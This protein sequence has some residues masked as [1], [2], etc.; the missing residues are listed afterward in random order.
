MVAFEIYI[1]VL[2]L[3]VYVMLTAVFFLFLTCVAKQAIRLIKGG[4][5]DE[6]IYAEYV[7][8]EKKKKK[9][10]GGAE[11]LLSAVFCCL[12]ILVFAFATFINIT[13]TQKNLDFPTFRVVQSGSMSKK[14]EK[15][16]YLFDN[17]L[18]DQIQ[19]FDLI[20]TEKLPDEFDLK[21]YD[22]VVY[23]ADGTLVVHR[24]VQI[25]EP[26]E[27]HPNERYFRFQGDNVHVAD[28]FP[29]KY[30]QMRG[31]YRG[32]RV[33]FVGSFISFMQSPA[34]VLCLLLVV[35][36]VIATPIVENKIQKERDKRLK[37][38]LANKKAQVAQAPAQK[39]TQPPVAF[40][41]FAYVLYPVRPK[42]GNRS[43]RPILPT[44]PQK[45]SNGQN[46]G[47]K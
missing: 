16:K 11:N 38:L 45:P 25:E 24:I 40:A 3:I 32:V 9:K 42:T 39:H 21:L 46:G 44:P 5:E 35:F 34:G 4:L 7:K 27:K 13:S 19:T 41:P 8:Q 23:E 12:M 36:G 15:N 2:C 30:E 37:E 29:V 31:I 22:I 28:K 10:S 26:N 47:K 6:K 43:A 1:F 17:N 20:I 33:P 18:N 14:Y